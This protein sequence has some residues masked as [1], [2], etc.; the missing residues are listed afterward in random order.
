MTK[1]APGKALIARGAPRM[2]TMAEGAQVA[3][4]QP[5]VWPLLDAQH[6]VGIG[7]GCLATRFTAYGIIC[8]EFG[9]EL[10]PCAVI[11]TGGG[12]RPRSIMGCAADLV[13]G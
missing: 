13:S 7:R 1:S 6:M 3:A 8:Q 4:V 11:A 5:E 10:P 12:I 9:A 2:V